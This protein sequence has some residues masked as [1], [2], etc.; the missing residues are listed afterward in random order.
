MRV[1]SAKKY[2]TGI[3]LFAANFFFLNNPGFSAE[4]PEGDAGPVIAGVVINSC[5][6]SITISVTS[7]TAPY[8]YAWEDSGGNPV[9]TNSFILSG[10]GPDNYSVTVTDALG[11]TVTA[12]YTVTDPPDLVGTVVVNNV[13]CRGDSDAQVVVTMSNGNP[14]YDWEL[15]DSGNNSIQTGSVAFPGNVITIG[16]LGVD[17]YSLEVEDQDGCTG[18]ITFNIVEPAQF[19]GASLLSQTNATCSN[20]T[21]GSLEV[22]GTGGWGGYT[23]AWFD[24]SSNFLGSS[25]T[26]TGLIPGDYTVVITDSNGCQV[27]PTYTIT[28]PAAI[29]NTASLTHATCNG[30]T[31]GAIDIS[32]AGG[33][34]T[35]SYLWSNGAVTQDLTGIGAGNY[36]VTVTDIQGCTYTENFTI[37]E[38]AVL[39]IN[40]SISQ[41]SCNGGSDGSIISNVSG[42]STSYTYAWST[43]ASSADISGLSAGSYSLTVTDANGCVTTESFTVT[44]PAQPLSVTG[45]TETLPTCFGG[46]DG[47]LQVNVTGGTPVYSYLW[48]TGATTA[49]IS[50][51]SAGAYAVTITDANGCTTVG[52][53]TLSNPAIITVS[54]PV[55]IPSC[56]GGADGSITATASNGTGPYTYNWNTGAVGQ[57]VN[58]LS[59]GTYSVTVTDNNG[60]SVV[61]NVVVGEPAPILGNAAVNDISCNGLTDGSISLAVTGGT[62]AYTYSWN[63]GATTSS[64]SGLSAGA[65]AVTITDANGC[66]EV[67]NFT[68]IDP[69]P[70]G[71]STTSVDVLCKGNTTGSIDLTPS[72][73]T[74]PYSYLW[75][76]GATT[77]DLSSLAAGTYTVTVTDASLCSTMTSVT[78]TEPATAL[79]V[80][81]TETHVTCNGSTNGSIDL[82]VSGGVGPYTYLW[83]TGITTEDIT[84]LASGN[85]SVQVTD[86]N[87]CVNNVAF[88]ITEPAPL[89]ATPVVDD[90]TCNGDNDG[91]ISLG[92][93]G[94]TGPYTYSWA[95]GPTTQNRSGLSPGNYTVTVTDFNGCQDVK[96]VTVSEPAVLA[97]SSVFQ[98]VNCFGESTGVINLTVSG[99]TTPYSYAWSNGS[100]TEDLSGIAAGTYTVTVTDANGCISGETVTI[101]EPAAALTYTSAVSQ[102]TCNGAADGVI[103]LSVSGG[104][105]PYTYNWSNGSTSEDLSSLSAAVYNVTITD[106][107]GC[108]TTGSFTITDPPL[109]SLSGVT[110]DVSCFGAADGAIDL[111]VTGGE[112]PY[113]YI[114]AHGPTVEDV[115]GLGPGSYSVQ[116]LDSRGCSALTSFTITEP[117]VLSL[118]TSKTDVSCFAGSDGAIDLTVSGGTGPYC[119]SWSNGSNSEDLSTLV[120]GSYTVTVTDLNGCTDITSVTIDQPLAALSKTE[121]VTDVSC[122]G[123]GNGSIDLTISGGTAPYTFAWNDGFVSEVRSGLIPGNYTVTITDANGCQLVDAYAISQPDVLALAS[124]V[125]QV[126][127][128]GADDATVDIVVSGGT[129]PYTY[130]WSDGNTLEDR[131]GLAPGTYSLLVT[132]ANGCQENESVT[133]TEPALLAVSEL[134]TDVDCFGNSTGAIDATISG[135]TAPYAYSWS[136]GATTEDLSGLVAGT[137]TLTVTDFNGCSDVVS[138]TVNEPAAALSLTDVVTDVTC[139]GVGNGT[140]DITVAGGTAPYTYSWSDGG[141]QEDK[142]A[143]TPGNY[144]VVVTDANGCQIS[145]AY[146]ITEP[147]VLSSAFASTNVSCFAAGDGEIDISVS[148]GTAPY[149]YQWSDGATSED[150]N[151][152]VPGNYSITITDANGCQ[153][154]EAITITE[155]AVL[156]ISQTVTDVDCFGN[157]TG[158]VD[159]TISGGTAPYLYSWSNGANTEDLTGLI[160]D[161]Y[162]VTVTDANG[163]QLVQ[164][165][166]VD[167]P[168][169]PLAINEVVTDISCFGANDGSIE[170]NMSG[171]TAPYTFSWNTGASS[172]DIS[173]LIVGNYNV[174]VTDANGCST[175]GTFTINSPTALQLTASVQNLSC[176]SAGD[177]AIDLTL[178][179]GTAPYSYTWSNGDNSE[180]LSAIAA[181]NYSVTVVDANGC[182]L[183][184]SYTVTEPLQL[185][186]NGA[187]TDV[188]CFGQAD[189]AI[190]VGVSGGV[191]PYSYLWS[192]GAVTQ[193]LFNI[194]GGNYSL[195]ITDANG[196]QVVE[197]YVVDEPAAAL[198]IT[199]TVSDLTCFGVNN[200]SIT[201]SISGGT[202]PYI[203]SW[204]QGSI[205]K[206]ISGQGPGG[207]QLT[208]TDANGC[209]ASE[210]FVITSPDALQASTAVTNLSCNG[211]ADGAINLSVLGGTGPYTYN[212]SSGATTEDLSGLA[213]GTYQVLISDANGCTLSRVVSVQEPAVLSLTYSSDDVSCFAGADGGINLTVSGGT[214]PFS[215]SW[216]NGETTED[217]SGLT[218]GSYAVT[219]TDINGCVAMETVNISEPTVL[220]LSGTA[221]D[222]TCN[223]L[224]NGS[225][226]VTAGGGTA[227]YTFAWSDGN[228]GEDRISLEPGTYSLLLTDANGCQVTESYTIT[229]PDALSLTYTF[230]D[231]S[232]FGAGDGAIQ[233]DI[234]GGTAPYSYLWSDGATTE[235]RDNLGPG[236]YTLTVTDA[237]NCQITQTVTIDE[238]AALALSYTKTDVDCFGNATG[239]VDLTVAG[240]MAP[241]TYA[242]SDGSVLQD[243]S[244]LVAGAYTVTV[245][246]INGCVAMETVNI[247]E[248]TAL[249]LSGTA[250]DATCNGLDNGSI[251]VTVGGG[252]A[253][254]TYAW[255]DGY[256]G[257]DRISLE[258]GTYSL[259]LTDANGCQVTESYTITEPDALSLTYTFDDISCFGAGDGAIRVDLIGGTAPYSYLWSDGAT[260]EDRDNLGPGSYTLTVTD[261]Q[262]CQITQTVTIDEPAVLAL[263]YTKTDV[264]CFG[265]ATGSVDLTVAGGMAPYTYAWSDGS[266]LQDLSGLVADTYSILVTDANGCTAT[267]TLVISQPA[268]ALGFA[269][270]TISDVSCYGLNDGAIDLTVTG[271]TAPYSFSWADGA[272]SEDRGSLVAGTYAVV[273]TDASGCQISSSYEITEPTILTT[274]FSQFNVSCFG[275]GD[276]SIDLTVSGGSSPYLFNWS[277][278]AATEDRS[279]LGPGTYAVQ[280]TDANGCQASEIIT[281]TEPLALT[282]NQATTDVA[283]FG[284]ST[285]GIDLTIAGGTTPY[286]Y[287]WSNGA[288]SEDLTEIVAGSYSVTVTDAQGCAV[289]EI[290][291]VSEPA[292]PLSAT[293]VQT[294]ESCASFSDGSIDLTVAGGTAPYTY[295]WNT[296]ASSEDISGLQPGTYQVTVSDNNG[297]EIIQNYTITGPQP[298]TL[299]GAVTNLSCRNA[300]DGA[301]GLTV[302]GG[303]APYSYVWSNG[304]TTEA[305]SSLDIGAFSVQVTDA[306][307]C[308]VIGAY[309][310]TQPLVLVAN[311][312]VED[313]SCFGADDGGIDLSV[314][315]GTAPYSYNW[316]NGATTQDIENLSG[317]AYTVGVLDANGCQVTAVIMVE[318]PSAPLAATTLITDAACQGQPAGRIDLAVTGGTAPYSYAWSNGS[319]Q[320]NL[321][322]AFAGDY[323]VVVTDIKGCVFTASYTIQEPDPIETSFDI[324]TTSCFGDSDGSIIVNTTGGV[325]PYSYVWSNG[326]TSKDQFNLTGGTYNVTITDANNCA[327]V[328]SAFVGDSKDLLVEVAKVDIGCKGE[329]NGAI[330]LNVT[331]GSGTYSYLW[332]DGATTRDLNSLSAGVYTVLVSD[333]GGCS[334]TATVVVSE[335]SAALDIAVDRSADM[336]CFGQT[337]GFA[338]V[339]PQGGVAPYTYLW[340]N[341]ARTADITGIPAGEYTVSVTDA[342][343]CVVQEFFRINQPDQP[344]NII[345]NGNLDLSCMG[346][347]DGNIQLDVSGGTAPYTY[348]W[349]TGSD[350]DALSGLVAGDYTVRVS[351]ALG[352]VKEQTFSV[353]QPAE[354]R[355][356]N[357]FV[358][359]SQCFD[360][361]NGSIELDVVGGT[362]PYQYQWSNGATTKNI[363]GISSGVYEVAITDARGCTVQ[364][365]YELDD[366]E[367]FRLSP[368]VAEISCVGAND[369]S[370]SLNIEGGVGA[371]TIRW[372]TGHVGETLTELAPGLY[373]VLVTDEN[374]CSLQQNFN[375]IEPLPVTLDAFVKDAIKCGDPESGQINL[376]VSGGRAPYTYRWSNGDTTQSLTE[377]FPGTYAV[378][379]TDSYGCTAEGTYSIQQPDPLKIGLRTEILVDC[380]NR[381]V[382]NRVRAEVSGGFGGY[383]Y[384]WSRGSGNGAENIVSEPGRLTLYITDDRGCQLEKSI[385]ITIPELGEADFD[386]TSAS[387]V[388]DGEAAANDPVNFYDTSFGDIIDWS[389]DFGDGFDSREVDPIHT[390]SAPGTYTVTLTITDASG[391]QAVQTDVIEIT[392]GYRIMVPDAFTPN[393]DGNNDFFRPRMLGLEKVQLL[394][395]NT[396]GEVIFNS[397]D[398]QTPGWDGTIRGKP[399]E[400]GNYVYKLV[401]LSFNGLKVEREG[402]FAL[403]N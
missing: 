368:E 70:I 95:D 166:T 304:A 30:D 309:T 199:G 323:E 14:D 62:G 388:R 40:E 376:I 384:E 364:G 224:D 317:G 324:A 6:G 165:V 232:C 130:A 148:G 302:S 9:G 55:T 310:I 76:N 209:T 208:V 143:L 285:G 83:N 390:Y 116:V 264:D 402:V 163:C 372:N 331:G 137:Y 8:S 108:T 79:A 181:G 59:A 51:L 379:V 26:I 127:C 118:S 120:S 139:N 185:I 82:T 325:G 71:V 138:Y 126:S 10:L 230:D 215:Y 7:G 363:I 359:E 271:G 261:A 237:Q 38:P 149:S 99:G 15:F 136:N 67:D 72:G 204:N 322:N 266:A 307:G 124:V 90:I 86:A 156:G 247:S 111:T 335:P 200:G 365:T 251:E 202:A 60:C 21:D 292:A 174:V 114:W 102:I 344:L 155:P 191:T 336:T 347:S 243:L 225:I 229:E 5:I 332:S 257:E 387:I 109:L 281:I 93:S 259:L 282:L 11:A 350:R 240:G 27:S 337:D 135:G 355:I 250:T 141:T 236:S 18:T 33:N 39:S 352:C 333:A 396:W 107:L 68:I 161:T 275:I 24:A 287:N 52:N 16:G 89:L 394:V 339:V 37:T 382:D 36:S 297:C 17:S 226:D 205:T 222:A 313:V 246:D 221:T 105:G 268:A 169:M 177:G 252:T 291:V 346:N 381:T 49:S 258:P 73:G 31:D 85:Y 367:L 123:L 375:I 25:S 255:S 154:N 311:Y 12:T 234:I 69:A 377:L 122:N 189:G 151:S 54:A 330:S 312:L 206:D 253:P 50:G 357:A 391:C 77:Q 397:E 314:T 341:G 66:T 162:T 87:G 57:T 279:N 42:G 395:F 172:E 348:L 2:F 295:S 192:N 157:A 186:A 301:I 131:T 128:F 371:L 196:C 115:T 121:M 78:I 183:S 242:W 142:S 303:T 152:L 188:T 160:A 386:F 210:S 383:Q 239:S 46:A 64:I 361:R 119:Y 305:I 219:V 180:D 182:S 223:G 195:T 260:S 269:A 283:C 306:N 262:N 280:I 265:N 153:T 13:T 173:G 65:Y 256:S 366:P 44:E 28:G 217:I 20:S 159:I 284:Q 358:N 164:P 94:G 373:N 193:D 398:V 58:G 48:S 134:I 308:T 212:W 321:V 351:D 1:T 300:G 334:T 227:P 211:A 98:N 43:G 147:L 218:A 201:T 194:A 231:I 133:I 29:T 345:A 56:N 241:Y 288:V 45:F 175:S 290:I 399:A 316:S 179:G 318:A 88:T 132:D 190:E 274:S 74:T 97:T 392:E 92:V 356:D 198:S 4:K 80:S 273:V 150:R 319:S 171:G 289:S 369:A 228:N 272:S 214:F 340:S 326:S 293:A 342:N 235:D 125:Q 401:G 263:S 129:A 203:Y 207:Y 22:V 23:Y 176:N 278:G 403:I 362:A 158:A 19:L 349:S 327:V 187:V 270:E 244:G 178:S 112:A 140:I 286:T 167:E 320:Q 197:N 378:T 41:V 329:E 32:P 75:S 248:P 146:T 184:R 238:P 370:I 315:G 389:W 385:D 63:T 106:A 400:N 299:T 100:T 213:A 343:G 298:L 91:E 220:T 110:K 245:T 267:E 328:R 360:D 47:T 103:N 233:V 170:L 374:G 338:R 294:N 35:F 53:Y 113:T 216:S 145:G 96:M 354:L 380:D 101:T 296:G 393:G 117:A 249:T 104:T 34:G 84:A 144:N 3:I 168:A 276:G 81:G 277:D 254:Y 353:R 61:Q